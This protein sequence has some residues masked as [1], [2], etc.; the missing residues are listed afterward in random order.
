LRTL[1][2]STARFNAPPIRNGR[3]SPEKNSKYVDCINHCLT[4][5][6][7][8]AP[9]GQAHFYHKRNLKFMLMKAGMTS[10]CNLAEIAGSAMQITASLRT[11]EYFAQPTGTV[12]MND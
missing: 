2:T 4:R 5:Q 12:S 9:D 8:N 6:T 10:F 7:K 3:I 1:L 11:C